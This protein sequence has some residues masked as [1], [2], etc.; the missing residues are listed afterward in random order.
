MLL[1]PDQHPRPIFSR[2]FSPDLIGPIMTGYSGCEIIRVADVETI[3]WIFQYVDAKHLELAP[4]VGFEPTTNRLTA[5]RSTTELRWMTWTV[6]LCSDCAE[7]TA[8]R[9]IPTLAGLYH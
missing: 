8:N 9:L 6:Y 7:A 4:A 1:G 2:E 3:L 5:D